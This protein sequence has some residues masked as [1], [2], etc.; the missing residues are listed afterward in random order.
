MLR[1]MHVDVAAVA[2][3]P[4]LFHNQAP[5]RC[6]RNEGVISNSGG[7]TFVKRT[8][9]KK[10]EEEEEPQQHNNNKNDFIENRWFNYKR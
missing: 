2:I 7:S 5:F 4:W 10:K 1:F 3:L 8:T 9:Q 6:F